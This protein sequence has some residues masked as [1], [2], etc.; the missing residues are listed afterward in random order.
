VRLKRSDEND[1]TESSTKA[2]AVSDTLAL[3]SADSLAVD[4]LE[5]NSAPVELRVEKDYLRSMANFHKGD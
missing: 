4:V 1:I 3:C 5:Q 2:P